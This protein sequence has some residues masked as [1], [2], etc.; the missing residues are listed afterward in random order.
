MRTQ[1]SPLSHGFAVPALPEGEPRFVQLCKAAQKLASPSG[2]GAPV[3]TLGRRGLRCIHLAVTK[4]RREGPV[5]TTSRSQRSAERAPLRSQNN[6]PTPTIGTPPPTP[7]FT[8]PVFSCKIEKMIRGT[9]LQKASQSSAF[10][11]A[12]ERQVIFSPAS[13]VKKYISRK[14]CARRARECSVIPSFQERRSLF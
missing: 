10:A 11:E 8:N 5:A 12:E 6:P 4:E 7:L 14:E 3:R 1:R 9:C 13:P 2:G